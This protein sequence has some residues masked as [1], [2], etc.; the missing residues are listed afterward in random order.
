[1]HQREAAGATAAPSKAEPSYVDLIQTRL[2]QGRLLEPDNDNA[3]YYLGQLAAADPKNSSLALLQAQV[4]TQIIARAAGELQAGRLDNAK[5]LMRSAAT[6]G[7]SPE[8]NALSDRIAAA[9]RTGETYGP[10]PEVDVAVLKATKPLSPQYPSEALAAGTQGWV[11]LA[12]VVT[13][14][15]K[16]GTITV[17]DSEPHHVFDRAAREAL[18]RTH[19]QPVIQ[20]GRAI[21]VTS[22]VRVSFR[23]ADR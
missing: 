3:F 10:I 18:A 16:V 20:N 15:G 9:P 22:R 13:T 1:L 6:L 11:D 12:F 4:Q 2:T 17:I 23:M 14:E 21:V 19:Y 5:S 8:L 7:A